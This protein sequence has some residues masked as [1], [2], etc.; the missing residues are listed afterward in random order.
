MNFVITVTFATLAGLV[1]IWFWNKELKPVFEYYKKVQQYKGAKCLYPF[2]VMGEVPAL[3]MLAT[4]F[5]IDLGITMLFSSIFSMGAGLTGG[6]VALWI[7]NFVS[8]YI[9]RSTK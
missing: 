9:Y 8:L 2:Y 3:L 1:C 6:A 7:S 4:P 5:L